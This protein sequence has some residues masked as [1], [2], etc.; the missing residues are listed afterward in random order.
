[1]PALITGRRPRIERESIAA[2]TRLGIPITLQLSL[3]DR[4]N[5]RCLHCYSVAE[6]RP[7]LTTQEVAGLLAQAAAAGTFMLVLTGGEVMCRRDL[8]EILERALDLRFAT[9]L[10]TNATLIDDGAADMIAETGV[11]QV[12]VSVY[13]GDAAVHDGITGTRGSLAVSLAGIERLRRRDVRVALKCVVMKP[14]L[15]TFTSVL[16]L[17]EELGASCAFDPV[18][19]VRNDGD[20]APLALRLGPDD[21]VTVFATPEIASAAVEEV[22]PDEFAYDGDIGDAPACSAGINNCA[23]S[24]YGDVTPCVAFPV[25]AGNVREAPLGEIWR[26]APVF[27]RVRSTRTRDIEVCATCADVRQ[28][29]RCPGS[30]LLEDG[31]VAGPS[32]AACQVAAARR[33][34]AG[35]EMTR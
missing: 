7:E 24:P 30:A 10:Y 15:A 3:T 33:A 8:A 16:R 13:S 12:H 29:G 20:A 11:H 5:L 2:A 27:L 4:C 26:Q 25:V 6:D 21:L 18:V 14:N 31:N 19:T 28:C 22:V 1:M 35:R 34:A 17:A 32:R 9:K 23:V